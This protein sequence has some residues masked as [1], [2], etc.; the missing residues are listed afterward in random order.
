MAKEALFNVLNNHID[1]EGLKVI[2]L[3]AGTGNISFEFASRGAEE[4]VAVDNNFKCID[5]IN[6]TIKALKLDN[7]KAVKADVFRFLN[8][9]RPGFDLIFADPPYDMPGMEKIIDTVF[10]KSLLTDDGWLVIEHP[11]TKKFNGFNTF[12]EERKYGRVHFS[13]FKKPQRK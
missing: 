9:C 10:E 8:Y 3:F 4:V 11:A 1:F 2:D 6:R 5:F 7:M 13:F 12:I